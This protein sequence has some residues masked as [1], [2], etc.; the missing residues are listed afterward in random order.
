MKFITIEGFE[1]KIFS[2]DALPAHRKKHR[3]RDCFSCNFCDDRRCAKCL[4]SRSR[5]EGE[6]AGPRS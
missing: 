1:G 4:G 5:D 3:C 2:P 6:D